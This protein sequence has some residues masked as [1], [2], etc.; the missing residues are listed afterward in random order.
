MIFNGDNLLPAG[1]GTPFEGQAEQ[2]H[3][4]LR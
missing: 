1:G 2:M 3:C 4:S